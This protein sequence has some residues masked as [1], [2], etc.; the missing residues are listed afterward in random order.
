MGV[1]D[2][3]KASLARTKQ[4]F[5]ERFDDIDTPCGGALAALMLG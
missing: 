1:F 5:V 3:I 4:Q 2:K